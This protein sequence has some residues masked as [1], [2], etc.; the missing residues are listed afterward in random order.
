[1]AR[2]IYRISSVPRPNLN[3]QAQLAAQQAGGSAATPIQQA[4]A[5]QASANAANQARYDEGL[6]GLRGMQEGILGADGILPQAERTSR[7]AIMQAIESSANMGRSARRRVDQQEQ[8]GMSDTQQSA[9]SRGLGNTTILDSLQRGVRQ[10]AND[11]RMDI[12]DAEANRRSQLQMALANNN[13]N[14]GMQAANMFR[15]TQGDI[16]N[17][18][19]ARNDVGPDMGQYANL[20]QQAT[21]GQQA[22]SSIPVTRTVNYPANSIIRQG[23][24][25]P[26]RTFR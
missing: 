9:I 15:G 19:A 21:A 18:I 17:F 5:D 6:A 1:M 4:V 20:I 7:G 22:A 26:S 16:T 2:S 25:T 13:A 3:F 8:Q 12:T 23:G 14:F 10:D 11:A 24:G